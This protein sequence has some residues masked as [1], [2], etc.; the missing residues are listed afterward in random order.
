[1]IPVP[2]NQDIAFDPT[3][4][5]NYKVVCLDIWDEPDSSYRTKQIEIYSYQ[6]PSWRLSGKSFIAQIHMEFEGGVFC[7]G[8]IH[9][10]NVWGNTSPYFNV[11]DGD[12]PMP[13]EWEDHLGRYCRYFGEYIDLQQLDL[14]FMRLRVIHGIAYS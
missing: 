9:W 12:L 13:D 11:D 1:M 7:N 2:G 10:L 3:K 8:A 5:L 4:S 6:T 14:M